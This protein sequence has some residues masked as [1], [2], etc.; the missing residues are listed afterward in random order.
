[1]DDAILKNRLKELVRYVNSTQ[2]P[3]PGRQ[4]AVPGAGWTSADRRLRNVQEMLDTL[5]FSIKYL[6]FDLEATRRENAV[7][8]RILTDDTD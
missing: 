4:T 2:T 1:M 3:R 8:R 5:G 6:L 7:L